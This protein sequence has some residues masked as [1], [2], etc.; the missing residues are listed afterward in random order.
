MRDRAPARGQDHA[1]ARGVRRL[2]YSAYL[3]TDTQVA[4]YPGKSP[5]LISLG[6]GLNFSTPLA[7]VNRTVVDNPLFFLR[8]NNPPPT[9]ASNA[10]RV[11]IDGRVR[12]PLALDLAALRAL[13]SLTHEVWLE[14]AGNSR[15]RW[16]PPGEG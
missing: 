2:G 1:G 15:S 8:S 12:Q 9:L 13:P 4:P 7:L 3:V 14:C 11:T 10:W 5:D 16:N 6:D